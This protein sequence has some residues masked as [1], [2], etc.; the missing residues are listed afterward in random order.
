MSDL[1][2]YI[3]EHYGRCT[4][5][6]DCYWERDGLGAGCLRREWLGQLCKHWQATTAGT[7]EELCAAM[8]ALYGREP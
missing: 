1:E 4:R 8:K 2:D 5:G 7:W 3:K 6:T